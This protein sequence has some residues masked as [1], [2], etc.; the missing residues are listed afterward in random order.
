MKASL[1][2]LA[3][4]VAYRATFASAGEWAHRAIDFFER[5]T[6]CQGIVLMQMIN[7]FGILA[8]IVIAT[9]RRRS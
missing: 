2:C 8:C 6:W 9:G 1:I 3:I 7:L 5:I 4:A